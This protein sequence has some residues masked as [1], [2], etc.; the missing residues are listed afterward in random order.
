MTQAT[1]RRAAAVLDLLAAAYASA[2]EFDRALEIS[3]AALD[4]KP[5]EPMAATMRNR[6]EMY[7]QRRPY[8]SP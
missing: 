7:R 3:Q 4:L 8:V 2:G 1:E 5:S 6:Q